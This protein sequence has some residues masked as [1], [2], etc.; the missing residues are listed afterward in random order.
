M[1]ALIKLPIYLTLAY[2]IFMCL[3]SSAHASTWNEKV[4]DKYYTQ[5]LIDYV[6]IEQKN[7]YDERINLKI[8]EYI[9]SP[10]KLSK[11]DDCVMPTSK[12]DMNKYNGLQNN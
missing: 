6:I 2:F 8:P 1:K 7:K 10:A 4:K 9:D 3:L 12:K 5:G 11:C